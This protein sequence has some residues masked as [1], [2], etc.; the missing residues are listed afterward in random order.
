M[1]AACASKAPVFRRFIFPLVTYR[2][3]KSKLWETTISP[4][5]SSLFLESQRWAY[6][7]VG[8]GRLFSALFSNFCEEI[9]CALACSSL[10]FASIWRSTESM[11]VSCALIPIQVRRAA[12]SI[13]ICFI[14]SVFKSF[15]RLSLSSSHASSDRQSE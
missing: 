14:R 2:V 1:V 3:G 6:E 13:N 8:S 10:L 11:P 9:S 15:I 4:T 12:V 7:R 5:V